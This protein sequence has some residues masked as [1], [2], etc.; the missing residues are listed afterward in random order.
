MAIKIKIKIK[1]KI[2]TFFIFIELGATERTRTAD[3]RITNALLYQL[4]YSGLEF[5]IPVS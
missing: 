4:S 3:P 1:M 5:I 2:W